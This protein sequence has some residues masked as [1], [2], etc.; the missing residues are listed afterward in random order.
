MPSLQRVVVSEDDLRR[1]I[2]LKAELGDLSLLPK[3]VQFWKQHSAE[4]VQPLTVEL[5]VDNFMAWRAQQGEWT[6]ATSEDTASRL[7]AFQLTYSWRNIHEITSG[8]IEE[9][10]SRFNAPATKKKH[11][12]KLRTLYKWAARNRH[13]AINPL[14]NIDAPKLEYHEPAIYTA[15]E[16]LAMLTVAER[17]HADLV[18]LIACL[19]FG[20]CRT[21]E[22]V[23]R[24]TGDAVLGWDNFDF[25]EG[26]LYVPHRVAK[27]AKSSEGND[28]SIPLTETLAHWLEPY[29]QD[30]GPLVTTDKT[31]VQRLL[32]KVRRLAGT[33]DI[34]NGLRHS[35]ISYYLAWNGEESYG[36]V[37]RWSG[38][39]ASVVRRHYLQ[40]VK[41]SQGEAWWAIRRTTGGES[42]P[43]GV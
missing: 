30:S 27:R 42:S 11:L 22:L 15:D 16:V 34:A 20:F 29:R 4:A 9:Y 21:S 39:S 12:D 2:S 35:C 5:A 36:V 28:R 32:A 33:R 18:P 40:V 1:V 3:V 13:V 23:P 31:T 7:R 19:A 43:A 38:N 8:D 14:D 25:K 17:E 26:Q 37:A 10:L 6:P 24:H 41:P